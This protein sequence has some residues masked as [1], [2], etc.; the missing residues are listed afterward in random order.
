[1]TCLN[2]GINTD[3]KLPSKDLDIGW[4]SKNKAAELL[5]QQRQP[6]PGA[7]PGASQ[8]RTLKLRDSDWSACGASPLPTGTPQGEDNG[9]VSGPSCN[10][11]VRTQCHEHA[12]PWCALRAAVPLEIQRL[13]PDPTLRCPVMGILW[14][15][16]SSS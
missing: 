6:G 2:K 13:E 10:R 7:T 3:A 4:R 8:R 11:T 9:K 5:K 15:S 1:L 12:M 14:P 16:S